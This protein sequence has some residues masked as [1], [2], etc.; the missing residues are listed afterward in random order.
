V[1]EGMVA[2]RMSPLYNFLKY[3]RVFADVITNAKE[4]GLG[5]KRF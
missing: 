1:I 3:F 2:Y 4:G 5:I